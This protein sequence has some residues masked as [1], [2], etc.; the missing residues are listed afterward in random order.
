MIL[1]LLWDQLLYPM[2]QKGN[3]THGLLS[4]I[5]YIYYIYIEIVG[6]FKIKVTMARTTKSYYKTKERS[7]FRICQRA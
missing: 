3:T 1:R 5:L 2:N 7:N 6:S 4:V